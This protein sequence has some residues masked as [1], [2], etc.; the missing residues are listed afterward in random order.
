MI[1]VDTSALIAILLKE[2]LAD[3]CRQVLSRDT[4]P[5]ISAAT[6]AEAL[7]VARGRG[8]LADLKSLLSLLPIETLPIDE[9]TSL[10]VAAIQAVWGKRNHPAALN[11]MDC[12]SYDVAKENDCPLLYI[13]NDFSQTDIRSALEPD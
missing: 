11:I 3:A 2:E 13:G 8:V 10:R 9:A 7:I 6:L 4:Q 12:F 1:A 5:I